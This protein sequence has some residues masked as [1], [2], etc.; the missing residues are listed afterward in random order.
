MS[1]R[2]RRS[3]TRHELVKNFTISKFK[4]ELCI[5]NPTNLTGGFVVKSLLE[6]KY[7][8]FKKTLRDEKLGDFFKSGCFGHFD[9][10]GKQC[11]LLK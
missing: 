8:D 3:K 9:A 1:D 11:T 6:V 4:V 2:E 10:G 5:D 7:D